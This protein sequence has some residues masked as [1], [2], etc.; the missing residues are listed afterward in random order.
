MRSRS[1]LRTTHGQNFDGS[2]LSRFAYAS[3][4]GGVE[5]LAPD[6]SVFIES[7]FSGSPSVTDIIDDPDA[8]DANFLIANN[9]NANTSVRVSFP[10]PSGDLVTGAGLQEIRVAARETAGS[11]SGT[12]TLS[13]EIYEAGNPT[14]LFTSS[15]PGRRRYGYPG[16]QFRL[17]RVDPSR[18]IG[19]GYR[20]RRQWQS[21]GWYWRSTI[22]G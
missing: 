15:T 21:L 4:G 8:A 6:G 16:I 18:Y 3:A 20:S 17:R 7:G 5:R 22:G 14:P 9:K 19:I 1:L 11:G 13:I 12:P 10:T 2:G